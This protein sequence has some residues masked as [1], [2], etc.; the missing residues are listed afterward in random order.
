MS[1]KTILVQ[2]VFSN[3]IVR[4]IFDK[5]RENTGEINREKLAILM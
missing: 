4:L 3:S 5:D 2:V 1:R